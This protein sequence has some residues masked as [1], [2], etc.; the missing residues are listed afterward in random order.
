MIVFADQIISYK[1]YKNKFG[2]KIFTSKD[3]V[4]IFCETIA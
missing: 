1:I 4:S 2:K 3:M